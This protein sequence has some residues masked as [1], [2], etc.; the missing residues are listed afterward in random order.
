MGVDFKADVEFRHV[1]REFVKWHEGPN[2]LKDAFDKAL[3]Q[4]PPRERDIIK[5]D[6]FSFWHAGWHAA[7]AD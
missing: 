3:S 2:G 5:R 6:L 1:V 7:K 4:C